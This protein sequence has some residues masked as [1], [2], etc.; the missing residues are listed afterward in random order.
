MHG[1]MYNA[2]VGI[3]G[4]YEPYRFHARAPHR[5]SLQ[6]AAAA[7]AYQVLLEYSPAEKARLDAAYA[8]SLAEVPDGRS[9]AR[10]IAYGELAARTMIAQRAGDGRNAPSMRPAAGSRC[11]RPTT[12]PAFAPF[13][14]P[15]LGGV[16]P[17]LIRSGARFD[18]GPPPALTS[19]RYARD[20][21]EVKALGSNDD[22]TR[23]TEQNDTAVFYAGNPT[24]QF[25]AA[26]RDQ[27]D[28]RNL[29]IVESARMFAAVQMSLA[30]ASDRRL[31]HQVP[32]RLLA[33]DHGYAISPTPTATPRRRPT[34]PGCR[35]WPRLR[36][37]NT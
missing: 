33:A 37:R 13:S 21:N 15:W 24:V 10:G 22:S 14:A 6:A 20:F 25:T 36:T 18:P 23:T 11:W 31:V 4:R 26:L 27:A 3:E 1:A 32:L 19:R 5:A 30:D 28:V 7:A 2:V 8:A 12:P 9:K 34:R 17:L 16:K 35:S 29:D